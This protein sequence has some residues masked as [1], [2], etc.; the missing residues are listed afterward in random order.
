[1]KPKYKIVYAREASSW[2]ASSP[3]LPG[4]FAIGCNSRAEA[5]QAMA[6]AIHTHF[7]M[8]RKKKQKA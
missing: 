4:V 5:R 7:E 3:D 6:I 1:M 2:A 8:L